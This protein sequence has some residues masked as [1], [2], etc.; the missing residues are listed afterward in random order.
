MLRASEWR[1]EGEERLPMRDTSKGKMR[2]SRSREEKRGR[3]V[4]LGSGGNR[5]NR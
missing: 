1:E 3:A 2:M 4:M 5:V